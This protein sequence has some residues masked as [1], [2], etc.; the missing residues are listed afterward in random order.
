MSEHK[1][2]VKW[3]RNGADYGYKSYSRDNVWRFDNGIEV[4]SSAAPAYLGNAQRVDP[5]STFLAA[6]SSRHMLT[7]LALASNKGFVV[8]SYENNTV[9]FLEKSAN[10]KLATTGVDLRPGIVFS[11][12]KL[13]TDADLNW[14]HDKSH[15][16]CFTT[17]SVTTK[18]TVVPAK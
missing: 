9:G 3:A 10:G 8:E 5:E 15:R 7:F 6:L 2:S 1:A 14:L 17:N 18:I 13:P 4:L 11:G 12:D 16:E